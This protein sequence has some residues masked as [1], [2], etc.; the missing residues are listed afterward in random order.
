MKSSV[1]FIV[2]CLLMGCATSPTNPTE[3]QQRRAEHYKGIGEYD[4]MGRMERD[5]LVEH[6]LVVETNWVWRA[7]Q[8]P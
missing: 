6:V 4:E 5:G 1:L 7:K 2:A 3:Q 8:K